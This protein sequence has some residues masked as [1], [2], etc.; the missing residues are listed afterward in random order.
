MNL[1]LFTLLTK[2]IHLRFQ[3]IGL[4]CLQSKLYLFRSR[5][6][7]LLLCLFCFN[8]QNLRKRGAAF[9]HW[10]FKNNPLWSF[11]PQFFFRCH[12]PYEKKTESKFSLSGSPLPSSFHSD[13]LRW[14]FQLFTMKLTNEHSQSHSHLL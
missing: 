4:F 3:V 2:T 7:C 8:L 11:L 1:L 12:P 9:S 14:Y 10:S 13:C 5:F 6:C